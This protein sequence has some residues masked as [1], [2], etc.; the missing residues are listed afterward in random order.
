MYKTKHGDGAACQRQSSQKWKW[1]EKIGN[2]FFFVQDNKLAL[3]NIA[4]H[5]FHRVGARLRQYLQC[6]IELPYGSVFIAVWPTQDNWALKYKKIFLNYLNMNFR[7]YIQQSTRAGRQN[8]NSVPKSISILGS[9]NLTK[10]HWGNILIFQRA[11][12]NF[13]ASWSLMDLWT[14]ALL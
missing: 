4:R 13:P 14:G 1:G 10:L 11:K 3:K 5:G 6:L 12:D 7:T 8:S 2:Q 9:K